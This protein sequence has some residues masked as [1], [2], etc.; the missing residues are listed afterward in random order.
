MKTQN[1]FFLLCLAKSVGTRAAM[2]LVEINFL[3][4][5][6]KSVNLRIYQ[7]NVLILICTVFL[8]YGYRLSLWSFIRLSELRRERVEWLIA[9]LIEIL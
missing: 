1:G 3:R 4:F 5:I 9:A 8:F 6:H 7:C 2:V